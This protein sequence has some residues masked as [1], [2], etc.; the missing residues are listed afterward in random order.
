MSPTALRALTIALVFAPTLALAH[1]GPGTVHG[2]MHGFAH[3]FGGLDHLLAMVAV[4]ALAAQL[5]GRALWAVPLGFV[6]AMLL[7]GGLGAA[8]VPLPFVEAGIAVSVV[9]LGLATA[10]RLHLP[11]IAAVALAA[12]FALFHGHAHGTEMPAE[13]SALLYGAGFVLATALL[14]GVG[15]AAVTLLGVRGGAAAAGMTRLGGAAMALAG[16]VMLVGAV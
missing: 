16:A 6:A 1:T 3:P 4:G 8:G 9:A 13:S 15:I 2:F 5:G 7:A 11:T 12:F 10:L 14:H